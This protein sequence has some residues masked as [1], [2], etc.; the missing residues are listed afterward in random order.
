MQFLRIFP[1]WLLS[2][3][4]PGAGAADL[5]GAKDPSQLPR[6]PGSHISRFSS[7]PR[8]QQLLPL[9][10]IKRVGRELRLDKSHRLLAERTQVSYRTP[11]ASDLDEVFRHYRDASSRRRGEVVFFCQGRSCGSSNYWANQIFRIS[12]LYGPEDMQRLLVARFEEE[13]AWL[14]LYVIERGNRRVLAQ[15]DWFVLQEADAE[16]LLPDAASLLQ[17]L[18]RYGYIRIRSLSFSPG[19]ELLNPAR[20][21]VLAA[22]LQKDITLQVHLVSHLAGEAAL[23]LLL[24]RSRK[25]AEAV[26][27]GLGNLGVDVNRIQ[28]HGLGPLAPLAEGDLDERI[29]LL[30]LGPESVLPQQ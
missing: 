19:D 6:F 11:S 12:S 24:Q 3:F 1:F 22:V 23:P 15:L 13:S 14:L 5:P 25:R 29:E 9:G 16:T 17:K 20:L 30:L 26:R 2:L 10:P 4:T 8:T 7:Q 18:R 28:V 21:E 27:A